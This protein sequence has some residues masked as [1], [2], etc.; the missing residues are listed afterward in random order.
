[1][2]NKFGAYGLK[3]KAKVYTP[4]KEDSLTMKLDSMPKD[5]KEVRAEAEK[6]GLDVININE[7]VRIDVD[8]EAPLYN[9]KGECIFC[10][11]HHITEM[12]RE[13]DC[14]YFKCGCPDCVMAEYFFYEEEYI[15]DPNPP[16][17]LKEFDSD[18]EVVASAREMAE[19]SKH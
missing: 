5:I 4:S 18:S 3:R 1:M 16:R 9:E 2:S 14:E 10:K 6:K 19:S 8:T 15:N 13:H 12:D 17:P 7:Y 11:A